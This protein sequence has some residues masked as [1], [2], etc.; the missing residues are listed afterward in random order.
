MVFLTNTFSPQMLAKDAKAT[1]EQVSLAEI[2]DIMYY[3][4]TSAVSHQVTSE[5]L[6]TLLGRRVHCNRINLT[7][8]PGDQ[9]IAVIPAFRAEES[10]EFTKAEVEAA[11]YRCFKITIS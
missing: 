11:G 9:V 7:L 2:V 5:V 10:R 1:V 3:G 6:T 8:K 4:F